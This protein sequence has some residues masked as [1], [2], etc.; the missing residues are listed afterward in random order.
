MPD[1]FLIIL[2]HQ[3]I[4]Q[5]MF[6][7]KNIYL[8]LKTGKRIRGQN[9][10]MIFAICFFVLFIGCSMGFCFFKNPPGTVRVLDGNISTTISFVLML[11]SIT[12]GAVSLLNMKDSWRVGV[13]DDQQ[14]SLIEHGIYRFSRNP[15]FLSYL[16]ILGSYPIL[17][18]NVILL[19]LAFLGFFAIHSMVRKEE[20]YLLHIHGEAYLL[21]KEKVPRYFIL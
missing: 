15:Y 14:T 5:G 17:L 18:Q 9:K 8:R 19:A 7:A 2:F 21:Y 16:L 6:F 13:V 20:E 10:E 11:L 3:L 4:F 1:S 12:I